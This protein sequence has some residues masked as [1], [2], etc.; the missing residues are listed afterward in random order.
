MKQEARKIKN[1]L[2][3]QQIKM[4]REKRQF[5]DL[6]I[7]LESKKRSKAGQG[8]HRRRRLTKKILELLA[9]KFD[10]YYAF[11]SNRDYKGPRMTIKDIG[12]LFDMGNSTTHKL[13]V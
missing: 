9:K 6:D 8:K 7:D 3:Q 2:K 1:E 11:E 13:Y 5:K 10:E 4:K 12:Q